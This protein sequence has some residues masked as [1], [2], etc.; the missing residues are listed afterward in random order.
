MQRAVLYRPRPLEDEARE[1]EGKELEA[2]LF[3]SEPKFGEL[4]TPS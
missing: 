1:F 4:V 2:N 3:S